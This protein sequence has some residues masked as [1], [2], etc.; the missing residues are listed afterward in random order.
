MP[1]G[2]WNDVFNADNKTASEINEKSVIPMWD[3]TANNSVNAY[4]NELMIKAKGY[5]EYTFAIRQSGTDAPT[6]SVIKD[7]F[8]L[9]SP[10]VATR[11]TIG[12]SGI[13]ITALGFSTAST[14]WNVVHKS[15]VGS[16]GEVVSSYF[17][18]STK[19]L[20][21]ATL[22]DGTLTDGILTN[23][24]GVIISIRETI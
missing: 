9:D 7:D 10:L 16:N 8:D 1:K 4:F 14:S 24:A 15:S 6:I 11:G 21:I 2:G 20:N 12:I 17:D 3:E 18:D 19:N 5:K 22:R 23:N 13:D